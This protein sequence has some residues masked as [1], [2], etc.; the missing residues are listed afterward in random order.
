VLL[1]LLCGTDVEQG[2][3]PWLMDQVQEQL[4]RNDYGRMVL[5]GILR[6][7]VNRR[8]HMFKILEDQRAASVA[9]RYVLACLL[10]SQGF[11]SCIKKI[12]VMKS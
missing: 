2:F 5:D 12:I 4:E 6:E 8:M 9:V 1:L 3:L 7:V 10:Y 11:N